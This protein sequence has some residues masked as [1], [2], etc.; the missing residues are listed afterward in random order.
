MIE[1]RQAVQPRDSFQLGQKD[2]SWLAEVG[3]CRVCAE[4]EWRAS[5]G[6]ERLLGQ[7]EGS[8]FGST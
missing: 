8:A 6:D 7:S 4:R 2:A 5:N 1:S 3:R